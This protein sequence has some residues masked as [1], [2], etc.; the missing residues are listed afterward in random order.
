MGLIRL[1]N[2]SLT[3]ITALPSAVP[4]VF[5][6]VYTA[7]SQTPVQFATSFVTLLTLNNVVV[8]S[9][10]KVYLSYHVTT[11]S[12]TATGQKHS[13][14]QI[15]YS[16]SS[17]GTVGDTSWGFGIN[18]SAQA[19]QLDT[20]FISLSD[21]AENPFNATGTFTMQFKGK[22]PNTNGYWA[23]EGNGTPQNY[24]SMNAMILVG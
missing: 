23:G 17:A 8:N 3:D 20:A 9:G 4:Q 13:A 5:K 15:A 16:G 21:F 10:E 7:N 14:F 18:D 1:S 12:A 19:H 2:Q 22:S 24:S 11:R 6:R